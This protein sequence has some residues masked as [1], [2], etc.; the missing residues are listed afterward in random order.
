[1]RRRRHFYASGEICVSRKDHDLPLSE[2]EVR[3]MFMI[4]IA[5]VKHVISMGMA[6]WVGSGRKAVEIEIATPQ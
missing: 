2:R 6:S 4:P 3:V 1:M 5:F